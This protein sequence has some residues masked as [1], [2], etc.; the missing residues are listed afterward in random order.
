MAS[1]PKSRKKT[2]LL[3]AFLILAIPTLLAGMGGVAWWGAG[4]IVHPSRRPLQGY[5]LEMLGRPEQYGLT[6]QKYEVPALSPYLFPTPILLCEPLSQGQGGAR[7]A[8]IQQDLNQKKIPLP[9]Y[10]DI[11]GT[12][13][14][15]HGRR[16]RKEDGLPVAERFCAAGFRC[17]LPDLPAH[18]DNQNPVASY[19]LHEWQLPDQLEKVTAKNFNLPL[20]PRFLWGISQGGSVAVQAA[21]KTSWQGLIVVSSFARFEDICEGQ[22]RKLFGPAAPALFPL[23]KFFVE[24]RGHYSL[25]SVSPVNA[26]SA[27][28]LPVMIAH[29]TTDKLIPMTVGRQLYGAVGSPQKTWVEVA[30]G[31]HDG[32]L[33]TPMP[34][35]AEMAAF[36]LRSLPGSP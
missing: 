3:R 23:L 28:Q 32:V 18:G 21:A 13:V 27:L 35:Y 17:I 8:K 1:P 24:S 16:G 34:L 9:N 5:H 26:A 4:Q 22:T 30:G 14:I 7:G 2:T 25:Q 29:G 10:G 19:G 20:V 12:I 15:L 36:Y 11:R 6:I 33:I 31:T